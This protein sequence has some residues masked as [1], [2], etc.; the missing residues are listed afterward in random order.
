MN[1]FCGINPCARLQIAVMGGGGNTT[2]NTNPNL[3]AGAALAAAAAAG[4]RTLAMSGPFTD[5][6]AIA[7]INTA[8]GVLGSVQQLGQLI[9]GGVPVSGPAV[10]VAMCVLSFVANSYPQMAVV[11]PYVASTFNTQAV[12][13]NNAIFSA[14]Q[15]LAAPLSMLQPVNSSDCRLLPTEYQA[16]SR[17]LRVLES[18]LHL[19]GVTQADANLEAAANRLQ[20][21][22]NPCDVTS[23]SLAS[24]Q[25]AATL[26]A[27]I[28][29]SNEAQ[30]AFYM[31]TS[32]FLNG[33]AG[34][35]CLAR[36]MAP[37]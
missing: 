4:M 13:A 28:E 17:S 7:M 36:N 15:G 35:G 16:V 37:S 29:T 10:T 1:T 2:T 14:A 19:S 9:A 33:I 3:A 30:R 27:T 31:Q 20:S 6:G 26:L 11:M 23:A 34:S 24:L 22:T 25:A 8:Q 5:P 12:N 32:V 18:Y 21:T